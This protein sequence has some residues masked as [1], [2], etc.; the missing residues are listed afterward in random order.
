MELQPRRLWVARCVR[1]RLV[2]NE[3]ITLLSWHGCPTLRLQ[4]IIVITR[5]KWIHYLLRLICMESCDWLGVD[6]EGRR[7]LND[8][9]TIAQSLLPV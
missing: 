8:I 4:V 5:P 3:S 2:G 1:N 6:G 9:T 7:V